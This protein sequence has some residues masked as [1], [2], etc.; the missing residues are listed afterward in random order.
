MTFT[1]AL[2]I[3]HLACSTPDDSFVLET[4]SPDMSPSWK[5]KNEENSP[6]EIPQIAAYLA[7]LRKQST[8]KI[9]QLNYMNATRI[10]PKLLN[11]DR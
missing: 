6:E 7:N 5:Q 8:K 3:R 11:D 4:D 1:R 2:K 10:L 9:A